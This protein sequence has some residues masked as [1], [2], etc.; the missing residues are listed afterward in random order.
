TLA[1]AQRLP[2]VHAI[3]VMDPARTD[4]SH[5]N[6]VAEVLARGQVKALKAYLGYLHYGPDDSGYRPYYELA[7]RFRV[8][9]IFHTGDTYSTRAKLRYAHPLLVDEVAVDH[10]G[11]KFVVAHLGNPW[12]T[13]A[14][15]VVYKNVNVWADLSG[16]AVGTV[17]DFTGE[18]RREALEEVKLTVGRALRYAERAN[19]FLFG[20]DWPLAPLD[21]YRALVASAVPEIYHPFIFEENARTLFQ[22]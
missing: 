14:A 19:R 3:G 13:E 4:A 15:E 22:L 11:V 20:S 6:R 16:L 8:P 17:E 18:E 12:L 2:G 21:T 7:E 5:M 9:V 1:V 10:P